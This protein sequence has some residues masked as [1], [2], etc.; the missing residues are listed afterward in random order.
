[1]ENSSYLF[2]HR[3]F[4][5]IADATIKIF[6][7]LLIYKETGNFML[8]FTY[9]FVDY[10]LT[11]VFFLVFRKFIQKFSILSI[12]L[13]V[14]PI[15]IAEFVLLSNLNLWIIIALAALDALASTLYYGALNLIFGYLDTSANT[16]KFEAGQYVGLI[17]FS[18]LSAYVLGKLQNSLT[19]VVIVSVVLYIV[20][21][22]PLCFKY[23]QLK[24][25]LHNLPKTNFKVL[26]KDNLK[27][28]IVHFFNGI[29][30]VIAETIFPLY[31]YT[32]GIEFSAIGILVALQ[33]LI[34]ILGGYLASY[35]T[36]KGLGKWVNVICVILYIAALIVIMLVNQMYVAYAFVLVF[37]IAH[38]M[39]F[40][41]MFNMFTKDQISKNYF[42][43]SIFYRDLYIDSGRAIVSVA[44][45][46]FPAFMFLFGIGIASAIGICGAGWVV[47]T[48][49]EQGKEKSYKKS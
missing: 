24:T 49:N 15:I 10:A 39:M 4:K 21:I 25:I 8:C 46:I 44:Y 7:P 2:L 35:L 5:G 33:Y 41:P 30:T 11:S 13:H 23:N 20:S 6:I 43:D 38:Q 9:C 40:V 48:S 12:I 17:I 31:L 34:N 32:K 36:K 18:I 19:F 45:L 37:S 14:F 26:F 3:I 28:S 1:M 47:T 22:V 16:A 29:L 42:H 27:F